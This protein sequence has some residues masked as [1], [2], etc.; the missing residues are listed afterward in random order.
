M[1]QEL[2]LKFTLFQDRTVKVVE[3]EIENWEIVTDC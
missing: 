3:K 2:V 1:L